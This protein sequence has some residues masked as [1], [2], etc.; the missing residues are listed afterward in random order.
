MLISKR[1]KKPMCGLVCLVK[2]INTNYQFVISTVHLIADPSIPDVKNLQAIC[3]LNEISLMSDSGKIPFILCGDFNSLPNS[4]VYETITNGYINFKN[5]ELLTKDSIKPKQIK[6]KLNMKSSYKL[7]NKKEPQYTNYTDVFNGTL[8]YIFV[9]HHW[10]VK[11][12]ESI[13]SIP[14]ITKEIAIPNSKFPSDHVPLSAD[15]SF[16]RF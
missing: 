16:K 7:L 14:I 15:L 10:N 9:S 6:Y 1:G 5:K 2:K 12:V 3:V 8:D 11:K 4:S 13:P